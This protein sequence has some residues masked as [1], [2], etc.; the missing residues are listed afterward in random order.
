MDFAPSGREAKE[1][2]V[3][4]LGFFVPQAAH[5]ECARLSPLSE[6]VASFNGR[7]ARGASRINAG[8]LP[9]LVVLLVRHPGVAV[10]KPILI[11]RNAFHLCSI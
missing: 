11:V 8:E 10:K 6:D 1:C 5:S 2:L 4:A 9:E 3:E 7:Q